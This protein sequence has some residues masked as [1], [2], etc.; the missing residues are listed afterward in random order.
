MSEIFITG[1]RNPD[2]D[3]LCAAYSYAVLKNSIDRVNHYTAV[4]CGHLS[5]NVSAQFG[6]IGITPPPYMRDVHPKV[7]DVVRTD[8]DPVQASL[9]V[10]EL[11]MIM[12]KYEKRP[13]VIP[14]FDGETFKG[15]LSIDDIAGWFLNDNLAEYPEYELTVENIERVL[16]CRT[17]KTGKNSKFHAT[18]LAGASHVDQHTNAI[19]VMPFGERYIKQAM[20]NKVP[21]IILTDV[22]G[23]M[24]ELDWGDYE[25]SVFVSDIEL[26]ETIRRLRRA[27]TVSNLL[28]PQG[29]VLQMTDM[30]DE[31]KEHLSSSKLRGLAVFDGDRYVGFVTRR[32]FLKK[33]RHNVILVDHN[34]P[35][36]S[37]R[38]V[39]EAVVHEIID[40]HRLDAPKTDLP[41]FIDAEPVGSTCTIIY[42]L[43]V[44]NNIVP[45]LTTSKVL[46][47]GILADTIILRSPTTTGIDVLS[48]ERLAPLSG[49]SDLKAFGKA[50]FE[51]VEGLERRNP[52]DVITA[53]MKV[54]SENG[55]EI[56]VGQCEVPTL[57]DI[58]DYMQKY[59]DALQSVREAKHLDWVLLMITDVLRCRS[60]LLSS[61]HK[62]EARL[63]YE[64]MEPH[65]FDMHDAVSRKMQLL[66][67]IIYAVN[68]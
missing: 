54:Y 22:K 48:A 29:H 1:H 28:G 3:T 8:V 11:M 60:I 66:P 15:L 18:I 6:I 16:Q 10:F 13:S 50:M 40:H 21:A 45:D 4:R 64:Q 67:E 36:Q 23:K 62:M 20:K 32:C 49:V 44:R 27:P 5:D 12:N 7:A 38:G 14:I 63:S 68:G 34:E 37:I 35:T 41:I 52:A 57:H 33:P 9:P 58:G 61:G 30:F 2:M 46:L 25:G 59:L 39:E 65:V 43:F 31:A 53:D 47:A 56:G 17:L 51:R 55:F 19:V 24:P 26:T 42:Q